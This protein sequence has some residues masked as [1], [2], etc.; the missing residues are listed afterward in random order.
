[1]ALLDGLQKNTALE[2]LYV[3][4]VDLGEGAEALAGFLAGDPALE[5]LG[6][7]G[8][9]IRDAGAVSLAAALRSN[10]HLAA[11]RLAGYPG[12]PARLG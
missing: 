7:A 8:N 2:A 11:L 6:L 4:A 5:R 1:M 12:G 3:N 10:A 9:E